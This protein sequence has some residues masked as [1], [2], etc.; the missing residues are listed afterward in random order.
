[1]RVPLVALNLE[2]IWLTLAIPVVI[3]AADAPC[4]SDAPNALW[5]PLQYVV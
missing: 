4:Q 5:Q 1:M 3:N 2:F